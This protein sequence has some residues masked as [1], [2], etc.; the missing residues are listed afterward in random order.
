MLLKILGPVNLES[1]LLVNDD[2]QDSGEH[3]FNELGRR[4]YT[5]LVGD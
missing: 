4:A 5:R 1:F 2:G 3:V